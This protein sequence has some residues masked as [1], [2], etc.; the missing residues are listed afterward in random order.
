MAISEV[1][2]TGRVFEGNKK[3]AHKEKEPFIGKRSTKKKK[4]PEFPM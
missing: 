1:Q 3:S 2:R 4:I